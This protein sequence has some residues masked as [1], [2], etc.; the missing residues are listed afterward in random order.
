MPPTKIQV[1]S[2]MTTIKSSFRLEPDVV[3]ILDSY[4]AAHSVTRTQAL[5][6][7]IRASQ[8]AETL[9]KLPP[10]D[11]TCD[12]LSTELASIKARLT[13]LEA[14]TQMSPKDATPE[15]KVGQVITGQYGKL[16]P[17]LLNSR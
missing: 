8:Q 17:L 10:K 13:K 15:F 12:D 1:P 2:S 7:L 9:S 14:A 4:A 6:T 16:Y 5:N 3:E 11:V